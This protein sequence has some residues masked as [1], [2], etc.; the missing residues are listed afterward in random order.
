MSE[1][2]SG[3]V[4]R[5]AM[6]ERAAFEALYKALE[7]PVFRFVRTK[8]NDP[9][10]C[11]DIVHD[12]FLDIWRNAAGF[13]ERSS[14]KTWVFSIAYRKVVDVLR[15]EMRYSGDDD[16]PEQEDDSPDAAQCLLAVQEKAMLTHCLGTLKPDHRAAIELTFMEELSYREVAAVVGVP[17]GTVKTRVFHA[18]N[19]LLR[20]L[21]GQMKA[22][23][24]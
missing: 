10:R 8:M 17:E 15:K 13:E 19:L 5:V 23:V 24:R 7:R 22:G 6:G 20:C 14:V 9:F 16:L 1:D 4:R 21:E 12:V 3:L 2:L 11:A 18:K